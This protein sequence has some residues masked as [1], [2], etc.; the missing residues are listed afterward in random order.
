[1]LTLLNI[2]DVIDKDV[3]TVNP[4]AT[5][6]EFTK[7]ISKSKRNLFAVVDREQNFKGMLILDDVREDMF[8]RDKYG[9]PITKYMFQ[10]PASERVSLDETM[11]SVM[12][13]FKNTGNYNLLV[14]NKG[15]FVGFVSR[16]N[17]FNAYRQTLIDVSHE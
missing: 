5:L 10:P 3:L 11:E 1:M 15:K 6:G 17:V 13:K 9:V 8:N 12:E 16:A 2:R 7:V 14:L 4:T